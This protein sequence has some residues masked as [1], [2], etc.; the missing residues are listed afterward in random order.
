MQ[1]TSPEPQQAARVA[2]ILEY[3]RDKLPPVKLPSGE[4]IPREFEILN[5]KKEIQ[6]VSLA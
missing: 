6:A 5:P 4:Q 3:A 1:V 2:R